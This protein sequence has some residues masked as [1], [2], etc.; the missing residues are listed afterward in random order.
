MDKCV[1]I[2]R[3]LGHKFEAIFNSTKAESPAWIGAMDLLSHEYP[4]AMESAASKTET[5]VALFCPHC[6]QGIDI[7]A[8][9]HG[10]TSSQAK[11]I[12][13]RLS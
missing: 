9:R 10:L 12:H 4:E 5:L 1:G 6:G 2:G 13:A 7:S 11:E 3:L 8:M